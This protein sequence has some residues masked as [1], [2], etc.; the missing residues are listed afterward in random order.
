MVAEVDTVNLRVFRRDSSN[1]RLEA[2]VMISEV[3]DLLS[4]ARSLCY[5]MQPL[6]CRLNLSNERGALLPTDWRMPGNGTGVDH[7]TIQDDGRGLHVNT[8][9]NESPMCY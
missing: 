6:L 7:V 2:A 4:P 1:P 5:L 8:E 3:P 9:L